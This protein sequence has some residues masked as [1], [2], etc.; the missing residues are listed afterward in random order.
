MMDMDFVENR[1]KEIKDLLDLG[2]YN[3][4][5]RLGWIPGDERFSENVLALI[6]RFISIERR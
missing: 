1:Q 5:R 3:E 2:K 4:A 6:E